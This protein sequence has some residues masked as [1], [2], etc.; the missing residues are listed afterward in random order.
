MHDI[1]R[2]PGNLRH[3]D[4]AVHRFGLG[5]GG[6]SERMINGRR[7]ALGQRMLHDDVN[8][9][10]ILRVHADER[11]VLCRLTQRLEDRGVVDHQHIG[12]R[13]EQ[14]EAGHAFAHHV[15]HVFEARIRQVGHNHV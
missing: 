2:H 7:F 15:V 4:R 3:G 12:I 10:T 14:L 13:H 6:T 1:N 8:D 9:G 11:A 5:L